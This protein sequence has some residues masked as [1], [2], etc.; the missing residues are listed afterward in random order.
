MEVRRIEN[1]QE[2]CDI[3]N[4]WDKAVTLAENE[5][6]FVHSDFII[7][8]WKYNTQKRKLLIRVILTHHGYIIGGMPLCMEKKVRKPGVFVIYQIWNPQ[9]ELEKGLRNAIEWFKINPMRI[10]MISKEI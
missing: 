6:P 3:A 1:I 7:C 8:W 9:V 10:F 4:K 5:N 2:F